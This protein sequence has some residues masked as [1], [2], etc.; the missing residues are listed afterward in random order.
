MAAGLIS[1]LSE[2]VLTFFLQLGRWISYF[3]FID[4]L[5]NLAI[6]VAK[7]EDNVSHAY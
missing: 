1:L 2:K 7:D 5:W 3:L 6:C 4:A